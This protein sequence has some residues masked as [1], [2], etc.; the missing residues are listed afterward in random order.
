MLCSF[1]NGSTHKEYEHVQARKD[2]H[3]I[4]G[5]WK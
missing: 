4:D 3:P 5:R 2:D 1:F